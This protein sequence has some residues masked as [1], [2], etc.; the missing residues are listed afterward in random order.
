M[1]QDEIRQTYED[2]SVEDSFEVFES[3]NITENE[4]VN[5]LGENVS[6]FYSH[7]LYKNIK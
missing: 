4:I 5:A 3:S 1:N 7:W 2:L 6:K